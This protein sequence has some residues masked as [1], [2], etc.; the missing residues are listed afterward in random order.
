[1]HELIDGPVLEY[2]TRKPSM[3]GRRSDGRRSDGRR[4]DGRRI[5]GR[6]IVAA[7]AALAV[8]CVTVAGVGGSAWATKK[9]VIP[10]QSQ[11]DQAN[12]NAHAKAVQI[13]EA[14]AQLA[15]ANAD[16]TKLNDHVE[17][18][19]EAY[20]GALAKLGAAQKVAADAEAKLA[21]AQRAHA[22]AQI[23]MNQFAADSYRGSPALAQ[24]SA[25]IT[26]GSPEAFVNREA[27]LAAISRHEQGV[28][29]LMKQTELAQA[30]AQKAAAQ[31]VSDQQHASAAAAKAKD[32]AVKAMND[33]LQQVAQIKN[34]QSQLTAQLAVLK[35]KAKNLADARA[36]GLKELAAQEAAA[37]AAAAAAAAAAKKR[38]QQQAGSGGSTGAPVDVVTPG[39]G[40]SVSSAAQRATAVA[41]ARDQI[42]VWYRW[43]G[44]GEVGPTVTDSGTQNVVGFDCSGLTMRA[45]QRAGI[46]LGHYTGLQWDEGMHVSRDQLV[47]GDLVF[48]ATDTS[49]PGT[50][51]H[52]G[53]YIG[54]GQMIDAPQTGE[55][56]GIHNAFRPDY[57]GAVQP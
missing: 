31:A 22:K 24:A 9:P 45:Y 2:V 51:H 16:L 52:V 30:T 29:N 12:A 42:G 40:R 1:V 48:F 43:A 23:Q 21:S 6:R 7:A 37:R 49:D 46:S 50:I 33:Q 32:D 44:A 38:Q 13:G 54:N 15:A 5:P 10:S 20:N 47:P 3:R 57:I 8:S 17:V 53:I 27:T 4:S 26:A 56:I 25:I 36:Q 41:F 34:T 55:Q 35:G 14:E 18:V 11:V 28:I 19:V 39:T